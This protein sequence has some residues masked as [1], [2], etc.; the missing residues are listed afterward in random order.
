[1]ADVAKSG[2]FQDSPAVFKV[3]LTNV[4]IEGCAESGELDGDYLLPLV[5][6]AVRSRWWKLSLGGDGGFT[7][8]S[9][10]ITANSAGGHD[11]RVSL[12][13]QGVDRP[14]WIRRNI[15]AVD[16]DQE[17]HFVKGSAQRGKWPRSIQVSPIANSIS[18]GP[19]AIGAQPALYSMTGSLEAGNGSVI[20]DPICDCHGCGFYKYELTFDGINNG[21]CN[22]CTSIA[23]AI[24]ETSN[25]HDCIWGGPFDPDTSPCGFVDA[26]LQILLNEDCELV[27]EVIIHQLAIGPVWEKVI[28]SCFEPNTLPLTVAPPPPDDQICLFGGSTVTV[29]PVNPDSLTALD[30]ADCLARAC[31]CKIECLP[32][33]DLN[34]Q[35]DFNLVCCCGSCPSVPAAKIPGVEFGAAPCT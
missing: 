8:I 12:Q 10:I 31:A 6:T 29:T 18:M 26:R 23:K 27:M 11:L 5:Q 1:M 30:L 2:F 17:P 28:T 22:D 7:S 32:P 16:S 15:E 20:P 35:C 4:F 19:F 24:V 33:P 3:S 21:T 9:I 14:T 13:G 25:P 34:F